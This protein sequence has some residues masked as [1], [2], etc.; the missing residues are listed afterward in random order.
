ME[1]LGMTQSTCSVCRAVI[2][3]KVVTDGRSVYFHK[4]CHD[5]G[6]SRILIFGDLPQY[7]RTLRYV[8][9]AWEPKTFVGD[10][11]ARCPEGCGFCERHEQHLCMPIIEITNRCDLVCPVCINA[12][13]KNSTGTSTPWDLSL[14]EFQHLLDVILEAERQVDVLNLSGGEPLLHPRLL[15]MID[16]ALSRKEIVRVSLSTNGLRFRDEPRLLQELHR[17]HVVISLQ[18]DGFNETTYE[19]LRGKPMLRKK[20]EILDMLKDCGIT[21]SLTMTA[22]GEVNDDQFPPMLDY[23]FGHDHVVSLMVQ[24]VA[25]VGRG[26]AI[27]NKVKRLTVPDVVRLLVKAGHPA[28]KADDFVPLPCSHPLCFSLAFY[29]MLDSGGAISVS[30]LTDAATLMDS[31]SNRVVFGLDLD[32]HERLKQMIYDLWSGPSG[33]V[34]ENKAVLETLRNILKKMSQTCCGPF[35]P[36]Q[37]FT[38]AERKV[39]SIFIHAFQD[40]ETFDLTRVRR[41]CQAYPQPDGKL[42]PACV[43][44][45]LGRERR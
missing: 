28:V 7:L 21:T 19:T 43:H 31:L 38:L 41:C 8:K 16:E 27:H 1:T 3:A 12:S 37:A 4:F 5:H 45:V 6:E 2:P 40:A 10:A 25:F 22:G 36:R 30:R 35:N 14:H 44:N 26:G 23:L 29:L 42:I 13:G 20:L 9:P 24:P 15:D 33:A 39:K 17:R 32:E 18:F 34:P 11:R